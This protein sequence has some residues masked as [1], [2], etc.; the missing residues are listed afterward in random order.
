MWV[1][2]F[3]MIVSTSVPHKHHV[4]RK[5]SSKLF[6]DQVYIG[7]KVKRCVIYVIILVQRWISDSVAGPKM[8]LYCTRC[9]SE[10]D[11]CGW[12]Q[13]KVGLLEQLGKL[14]CGVPS[15]R[16][17]WVEMISHVR[18]WPCDRTFSSRLP[19]HRQPDAETELTVNLPNVSTWIYNPGL[20]LTL[21]FSTLVG[22]PVL[23]KF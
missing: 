11:R 7:F 10:A 22:R 19:S 23:A 18:E 16:G 21:S 3:L 4:S 13:V 15:Q 14:A 6:W 20:T 5:P 12:L 1:S 2:P 9:K 17:M 8:N